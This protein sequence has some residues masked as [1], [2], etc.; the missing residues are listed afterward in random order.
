MVCVK[1]CLFQFSILSHSPIQMMSEWGRR[2]E[3]V[4]TWQCLTGMSWL[5]A[6]TLPTKYN[7]FIW[8]FQS[9]LVL[10]APVTQH[11]FSGTAASDGF[12]LGSLWLVWL[13][14]KQPDP[15]GTFGLFM[16]LSCVVQVQLESGSD[17]CSTKCTKGSSVFLTAL[18]WL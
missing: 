16:M 7:H 5:Y 18:A 11:S 10:D 13:K 2:S 8:R 6:S 1:E 17:G 15:L 12:R 3:G 9:R 4:K 14:R